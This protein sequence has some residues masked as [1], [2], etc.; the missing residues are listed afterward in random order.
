[1]SFMEMRLSSELV[2]CK[3]I[4]IEVDTSAQWVL[5]KFALS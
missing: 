4:F 2:F 5:N 3:Y 1:M